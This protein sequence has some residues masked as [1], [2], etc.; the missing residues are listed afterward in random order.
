MRD[1]LTEPAWEAVDLGH[2]LPDSS[3]AVSVALPCWQDVV[4]YEEE[5]PDLLAALRCGYP[6]FFCHPYVRALFDLAT[7]RF[8]SGGR[9][10]LVFPSRGAAERC[11]HYVGDGGAELHDFGWG[12]LVAITLGEGRVG[13]ALE[14]WR[15]SGEIV[16]SRMAEAA[17]AGADVGEDRGGGHIVRERL[18]GLSGESSEDVFLFGSG[19]Q[20]TFAVCRMMG[21]LRPGKKS[22]QLEFPYVDVLKIQERFGMGAHFMPVVSDGDFGKIAEVCNG[23][24]SAVFCELT[25]NPLMRSIDLERLK[26][27]LDREG[28][29]LV[30]DDTV[31]SVANV[32][33]YPFADVV[34][35]SLT[36]YFAGTG[37]V[38]AGAVTVNGRSPWA[39]EMRGWLERET[40]EGVLWHE[41]ITVLEKASR[42]YSQRMRKV[43]ANGAALYEFL[44]AHPKVEHVFYP[45]GETPALYRQI[46]R[47]DGGYGGL[48]SVVLKGEP[49]ASPVFYDALR[50]SKGPS[51]GTSFTLAC[52][53]TLLAHYNELA[54]A[55]GCGIS[56][57][58]IRIG[59][60]T[61]DTSDLLDRFGTALEKC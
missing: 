53:Y 26:P 10:A 16:S 20:A 33:V 43:N 40:R 56:P 32:D 5:D 50:V 49:L 54:W 37:D 30:I 7:G 47:P 44:A 21:A 46:R 39:S 29:P 58:L 18:A 3:H 25:S 42:G 24:L 13:K 17:L 11:A 35:T 41:D 9:R 27:L 23:G 60:G 59:A 4:R 61:E 31:A 15:F 8:A 57:W 55:E 6:R 52:P 22:L 38:M 48:L 34:T 28:V 14:Y 51:F 1:L 45:L 12:R 19:M 2:P 36:K